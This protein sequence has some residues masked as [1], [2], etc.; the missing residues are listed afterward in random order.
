MFAKASVKEL[1]EQLS[2]KDAR[3]FKLEEHI[4]QKNERIRELINRCDASMKIMEEDLLP[5]FQS[6]ST[7]IQNIPTRAQ[8][9]G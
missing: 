8:R 4:R 9:L 1:K 3:I 5:L 7:L 2:L 6:L